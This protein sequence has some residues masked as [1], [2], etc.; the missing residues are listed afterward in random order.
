MF[1]LCPHNC[2][3]IKKH[4]FVLETSFKNMYNSKAI[5][6][7]QKSYPVRR[8]CLPNRVSMCILNFQILVFKNV[9]QRFINS[10]K[11]VRGPKKN[12]FPAKK[13]KFKPAVLK[14]D[15]DLSEQFRN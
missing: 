1:I 8:E 15:T 3:L 12:A 4:S 10:I 5:K 6:I 9:A 2:D 13:N 14:F 7:D 11:T